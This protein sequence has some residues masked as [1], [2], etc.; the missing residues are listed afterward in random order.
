MKEHGVAYKTEVTTTVEPRVGDVPPVFTNEIEKE[1]LFI[2]RKMAKQ[3]QM[4]FT[5]EQ[6][7]KTYSIFLQY[8]LSCLLYPGLM[9]L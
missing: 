5:S 4:T 8:Q 2:Q 6:V 9:M 3:A 1:Q 7:C